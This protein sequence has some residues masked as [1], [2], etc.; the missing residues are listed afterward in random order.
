MRDWASAARA[1]ADRGDWDEAIAIVSSVAECY[2]R[3]HNRHVAHLW[4]MHLLARAERLDELTLLA[5][6]D[7]HARRQL[8]RAL[9]HARDTLGL[10]HRA[11]NGDKFALY[12]LLNALCDQGEHTTAQRVALELASANAYA[13]RQLLSDSA[14]GDGATEPEDGF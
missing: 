8:D 9:Y 12:K 14:G 13:R 6:S 5:E 2:S 4:H 7:V 1:A 11:E 3:D 10:R